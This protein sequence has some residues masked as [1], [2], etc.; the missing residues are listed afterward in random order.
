M[1]SSNPFRFGLPC[2]LNGHSAEFVIP[3]IAEILLVEKGLGALAQEVKGGTGEEVINGLLS[4]LNVAT[5]LAL[6]LSFVVE[7]KRDLS[8]E[9]IAVHDRDATKVGVEDHGGFLRLSDRLAKFLFAQGFGRRG[10][11]THRGPA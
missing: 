7:E 5:I 11:L 1:L 6:R 2:E 3:L 9:S 8:S 4:G 10:R